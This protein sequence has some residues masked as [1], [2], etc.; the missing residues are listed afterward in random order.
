[1][2]AGPDAVDRLLEE[3]GVDVEAGRPWSPQRA[4]TSSDTS[5]LLRGAWGMSGA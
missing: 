1:M 3:P 2:V 5:L 4:F